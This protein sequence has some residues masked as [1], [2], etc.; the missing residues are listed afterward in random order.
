M[1]KIKNLLFVS[2]FLMS[3]SSFSQI[4]EGEDGLYYS[5]DGTL[6]TGSYTEYYP[7]G[8]KKIEMT[9]Q[10]GTKDGIIT[11]FFE[12]GSVNELRSYKLNKKDGTWT[13]YNEKGQKIATAI[14][15]N[16]SL[17]THIKC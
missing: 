12:D 13:T 10:S 7:S 3:V 9:I 4:T 6:Y 14:Y 8:Q 15:N 1:R 17:K 5:K 11:I 2:V 16:S